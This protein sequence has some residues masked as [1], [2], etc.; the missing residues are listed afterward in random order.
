MGGVECFVDD[1]PGYRDWLARHPDGFVINAERNPTAAYL[2]LHH[3]GCRTING[4][5]ARGSTFTGDYIKVCGDQ[6]ELEG[7]ARQLPES[8]HRHRA[9]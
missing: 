7:F 6:D 2:M 4:V 1:D 3:A 5:P 9:W 8:T